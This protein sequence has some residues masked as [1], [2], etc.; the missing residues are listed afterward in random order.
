MM[1]FN[2]LCSS[3]NI[4][5]SY[6]VISRHRFLAT[7]V[8][9]RTLCSLTSRSV[10]PRHASVTLNCSNA[11]DD[12]FLF[13]S[14]GTVRYFSAAAA[15]SGDVMTVFDRSA[16]RRQRNLTADL[17]DYNLYDYLKDE[18]FGDVQCT[19]HVVAT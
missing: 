18:V 11:A 16:K 6:S 5:Q 12:Q 15:S 3:L 13:R 17:P 10:S 14:Y 7:F 1:P 8:N 9:I 2:L 4:S 19:H